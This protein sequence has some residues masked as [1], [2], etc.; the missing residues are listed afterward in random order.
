MNWQAG[1]QQVVKGYVKRW[2][3]TPQHWSMKLTDVDGA[4]YL[5]IGR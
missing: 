3:A 5:A 1:C 2:F 4:P